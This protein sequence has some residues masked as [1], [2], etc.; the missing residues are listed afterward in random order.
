MPMPAYIRA[1]LT[2]WYVFLLAVVLAFFD[3]AVFLSLRRVLYSNLDAS[4]HS[5]ADAILRTIQFEEEGQFLTIPRPS[6]DSDDDIEQY[7]HVFDI[8]K[9]LVFDSTGS[10]EHLFVD[11][12]APS[13]ALVGDSRRTPTLCRVGHSPLRAMEWRSVF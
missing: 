1:R 9:K 3:G 8:S 13:R 7:V 10:N 11:S 2:L 12:P 4:I 5:S 6:D